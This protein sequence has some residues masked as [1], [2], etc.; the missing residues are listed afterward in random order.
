MNN[1]RDLEQLSTNRRFV[2]AKM[3]DGPSSCGTLKHAKSYSKQLSR[4][5]IHVKASHLK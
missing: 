4:Y 2:S 5:L 1:D 3:V